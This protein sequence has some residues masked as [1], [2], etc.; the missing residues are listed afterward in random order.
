M[1]TKQLLFAYTRTDQVVG[2]G[3]QL[4]MGNGRIHHSI[5]WPDRACERYSEAML[6]NQR[7]ACDVA[8]FA[9][10]SEVQDPPPE[11]GELF[12]EAEVDSAIDDQIGSPPPVKIAADP[13]VTNKGSALATDSNPPSS[14]PPSSEPSNPSS[15]TA[16]APV[17]NSTI[18]ADSETSAGTESVASVVNDDVASDPAV[19]ESAPPTE[20]PAAEA[21]SNTEPTTVAE[22]AIVN[23]SEP[24]APA[25]V[26]PEASSAAPTATAP[27]ASPA[28]AANATP[29]ATAEATAEATPASPSPGSAGKES[30]EVARKKET[31]TKL[32]SAYGRILNSPTALTTERKVQ[33]LI[34]QSPNATDVDVIR[35]LNGEGVEVSAQMVK[36]QRVEVDRLRE[37]ARQEKKQ[38]PT[39]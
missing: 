6:K 1:S 36:E 2:Y 13:V 31:Q 25:A 27:A 10:E 18:K 7:I 30:A 22:T 15:P 12:S 3:F 24:V 34:A 14:I 19:A 28:P 33:Y 38:K 5:A 4:D 11:V 23:D 37:Q 21:S 35:F 8:A 16:D 26:E 17:A 29:A 20:S 39:L 9:V 32:R